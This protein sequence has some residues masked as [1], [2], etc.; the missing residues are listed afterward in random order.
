MVDEPESLVLRYLRRID[1]RLDRVED[2]L[3]E[4]VLRVSSVER[5]V[6]D[7]RVDFAGMQA[8]MDHFDRRLGRIETR[9]DLAEV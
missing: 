1:E 8:R 5:G 3:G 2:K 4:L 6:A 7:M 9:L